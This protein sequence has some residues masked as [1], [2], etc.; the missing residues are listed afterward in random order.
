LYQIKKGRQSLRRPCHQ[1]TIVLQWFFKIKIGSCQEESARFLKSPEIPDYR[2]YETIT[3][4]RNI[5]K[6]ISAIMF[7]ING[8][9]R[10]KSSFSEL[11]SKYC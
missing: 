9:K 4:I 3:A 7:Q 5:L 6:L 8:I 11:L 1:Y 2:D 10:A